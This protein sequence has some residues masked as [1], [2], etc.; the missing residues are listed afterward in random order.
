[1]YIVLSQEKNEIPIYAG[2][3]FEDVLEFISENKT[4][5]FAYFEGKKTDLYITE[6]WD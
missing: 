4:F 2:D 6:K 3:N 5:F 1:M